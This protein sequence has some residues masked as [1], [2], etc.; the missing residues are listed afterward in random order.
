[1]PM[2]IK[3][4]MLFNKLERSAKLNVVTLGPFM[5]GDY[6]ISKLEC[7]FHFGLAAIYATSF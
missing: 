5:G 2:F 7:Y 3:L 6:S 1:M 4:F